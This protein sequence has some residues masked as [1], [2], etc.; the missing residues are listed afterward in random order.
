MVGTRLR[1]LIHPHM[2]YGAVTL[3]GQKEGLQML[4]RRERKFLKII[5]VLHKKSDTNR[6]M[7]LSKT[8]VFKG[9]ISFEDREVPEENSYGRYMKNAT[10]SLLK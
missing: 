7:H 8:K 2:R 6:Y 3:I 5:A 4:G 9:L 1:G 10:E